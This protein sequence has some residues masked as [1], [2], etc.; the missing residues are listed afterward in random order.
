MARATTFELYISITKRPMADDYSSQSGC[1][2]VRDSSASMSPEE[3][4]GA[5]FL[6]RPSA[7]AG[8]NTAAPAVAPG[9]EMGER[10][11]RPLV[12][13]EISPHAGPVVPSEG[14][15]AALTA[16]GFEKAAAVQALIQAGG[17]VPLAADMLAAMSSDST[18]RYKVAAAP[19]MV[20]AQSHQLPGG[21]ALLRSPSAA[22][23]AA[24][25]T[26]ISSDED[27]AQ[28][29][30]PGVAAAEG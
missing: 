18:G 27:T 8:S 12:F 25:S 30:H 11:H 28:D 7:A 3:D 19:S 14:A 23:S 10:G 16:M 4:G 26:D 15:V 9:A 22:L 13:V 29:D 6:S 1:D 24:S 17:A 21:H 20:Q 2:E 5:H